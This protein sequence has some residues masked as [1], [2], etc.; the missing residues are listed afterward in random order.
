M[1][2][3]SI[4]A[5]I[6]VS[7]QDLFT[8]VSNVAG[9]GPYS[10]NAPTQLGQRAT[11]GDGRIFRFIQAGASNLAAG[12][13]MQETATV[14]N[15]QN[16]V[17]TTQAVGDTTVTVTLGGT[18][19]TLN[20]YAGGYAIVI[21]GTGVGQ[22]LKIASNPAQATTTGTVVLTLDDPFLIAT[23]T[24]DTKISL[25][26]P[27]Y[28]GVVV[29]PATPTGSPVGVTIVAIT[30]LYYGWMQTRG[31]G[32]CLNDGGTTIGLGLATSGAV[33]G[34]VKT[35]WA[36]LGQVG[37]ATFTGVDTQYSPLWLNID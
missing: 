21:A 14:A 29:N 1:A 15:H 12:K 6:L 19:A 24:A 22:I 30:A 17:S 18:A 13:L 8:T 33:A 32:T 28:N 16:L 7:P 3:S 9:V 23:A 31:I 35:K 10:T 25:I 11:T 27:P 37:W 5:D 36:T 4:K 2:Q 20:Q 26:P 34:A